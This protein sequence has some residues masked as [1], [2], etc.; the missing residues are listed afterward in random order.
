MRKAYRFLGALCIFAEC[1]PKNLPKR[2]GRVFRRPS[3]RATARRCRTN[4]RKMRS[5][6][7]LKV[8]FPAWIA[9]RRSATLWSWNSISARRTSVRAA[10]P[11]GW[12]GGSPWSPI[13]RLAFSSHPGR[14]RSATVWKVLRPT[15]APGSAQISWHNST[16]T[17][18]G[19]ISWRFPTIR[20]RRPCRTARSRWSTC[21]GGSGEPMPSARSGRA[22]DG[23]SG[24][25]A[26][27]PTAGSWRPITPNG[28][29]RPN[30]AT[31]R[32]SVGSSGP[33]GYW[34]ETVDRKLGEIDAKTG[35]R[36]RM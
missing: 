20:W 9:P 18:A 4:S 16:L 7:R 28:R 23:R 21:A 10:H 26:R 15:A 8:I 3:Y 29:P 22:A 36:D 25:R 35:D 34:C 17:R 14:C 31:S 12:P 5:G 33:R 32:S 2:F 1:N 30:P 13:R 27:P 6:G 11:N 19:A 24:G